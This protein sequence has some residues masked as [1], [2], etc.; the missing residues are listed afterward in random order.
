MYWQPWPNSKIVF[1]CTLLQKEPLFIG[2]H[3]QVH[4]AHSN[5][6]LE[7]SEVVGMLGKH[8]VVGNKWESSVTGPLIGSV[9]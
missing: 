3:T 2:T 9:R 8:K 7:A 5:F 4:Y 1:E 6:S